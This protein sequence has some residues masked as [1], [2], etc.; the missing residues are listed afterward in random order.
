MPRVSAAWDVVQ[1]SD[2][3][4]PA[5]GRQFLY[6]KSDGLLY[7]K[8]SSGVVTAIDSVPSVAGRTGAITLTAADIAAG[9]YPSGS[10][11]YSGDVGA[12]FFKGNGIAGANATTSRWVGT[13]TSGAPSSG[14]FL[15]GDFIIAQNGHI[16][17]CTVGGSPGTWVDTAGAGGA[18]TSVA[19]R[20]GVVTLTAADIAAGTFPAGNFVMAGNL[21]LGTGTGSGWAFT[22]GSPGA[23]AASRYVGAT[24]SG[25]PTG[26][27]AFVIGDFVISQNGSIWIC[28]VAGSPGTWVEIKR[29]AALT[30]ADISAGTFPAGT[31]NFSG[32]LQEAGNRVYS[33]G[34]QNLSGT[35]SSEITYGIAATAGSNPTYSSG[36]HSHGTPPYPLWKD[37]V[38]AASTA[39]VTVASALINGLVMDGVTLATGDRVLLKNQTAPAENGIYVVVASGAASRATDADT[40][41]KVFGMHVPVLAGTLNASSEW[42]MTNTA[43]PTLGTTALTFQQSP[44]V[45]AGGVKIQSGIVTITFTASAAGTGTITFSPAFS[46]VPVIVASIIGGSGA[47][48]GTVRAGQ[49]ATAS[50]SPVNCQATATLT[51]TW[52]VYWIAIGT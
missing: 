51:T 23:N 7:T 2:P 22:A 9:T 4:T 6:F 10:F 15:A 35:V 48:G 21:S 13:T 12:T 40:A 39:N 24:T 14:T 27:N 26:A 19:G 8:K 3:A 16:W 49:A 38:R 34:N 32:T 42:F 29:A 17:I 45:T 31:F 33:F 52:T 5:A 20:T 30:A 11:V 41:A 50:S 44:I 47:T 43:S 18:V 36:N 28:T 1:V 25:A 46:T 37:P